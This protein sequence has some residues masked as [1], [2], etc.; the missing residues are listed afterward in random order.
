MSIG[1]LDDQ[2]LV[3]NIKN[4]P[5]RINSPLPA[6]R[7]LSGQFLPLPGLWMSPLC[8]SGVA[9]SS[10]PIGNSSS[11]SVSGMNVAMDHVP[12]LLSR[13]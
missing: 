11:E 9:R 4:G 6:E 5:I 12:D 10:H 1:V 8:P 7:Q 13:T 3:L 2:F